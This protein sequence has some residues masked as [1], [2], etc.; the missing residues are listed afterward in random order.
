M[1]LPLFIRNTIQNMETISI[2][3]IPNYPDTI[4]DGEFKGITR[5]DY[6]NIISKFGLIPDLYQMDIYSNCNI[7]HFFPPC[8]T[9]ISNEIRQN[10][11]EKKIEF[12]PVRKDLKIRD[13]IPNNNNIYTKKSNVCLDQP[14]KEAYSN[15]SRN[16]ERKET[17]MKRI[18]ILFDE[19]EEDTSFEYKEMIQTKKI[20]IEG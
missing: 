14:V 7:F 3:S 18:E 19:E 16:E 10:N 20:K 2:I 8:H 4:K 11:N 9:L 1:I 12:I 6:E 15:F 13:T 17:S 5:I